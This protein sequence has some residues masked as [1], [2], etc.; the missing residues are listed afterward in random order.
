M[1]GEEVNWFGWVLVAIIG[2]STV[3]SIAKVGKP[4][5]PTTPGEL[6]FIVIFNVL[7]IVGVVFVGVD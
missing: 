4:R 5:K 2:L 7:M 1:M 3:A 6:V